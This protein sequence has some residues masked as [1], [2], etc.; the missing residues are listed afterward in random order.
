MM[1]N[2]TTYITGKNWDTTFNLPAPEKANDYHIQGK[3]HSKSTPVW[4][5]YWCGDNDP[6][7]DWELVGHTLTPSTD[8]ADT[9]DFSMDFMIKDYQ[10][11]ESGTTCRF[12]V[13]FKTEILNHLDITG[14]IWTRD[15]VE[16]DKDETTGFNV[17]D[18]AEKV[19]TVSFDNRLRDI[20]SRRIDITQLQF[21][22]TDLQIPIA[23]L[24]REGLGYPGTCTNPR[25]AG[26]R[27][28][29]YPGTLHVEPRSS[30]EINLT[31]LGVHL[32]EGQFLQ[33][34]Y[35][36]PATGD[37]SWVQ[38]EHSTIPVPAEPLK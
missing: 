7:T 38:H 9:W 16:I 32:K 17:W 37:A 33:I 12:G 35:I 8:E 25:Y 4:S 11:I 15:L 29:S 10:Y 27:W 6:D 34:R 31:E 18:N 1:V 2:A 19:T 20:L 22:V 23:D 13:E 26:I 28:I 30:V 14:M 3:I 5:R 36:D 24:G 21:A